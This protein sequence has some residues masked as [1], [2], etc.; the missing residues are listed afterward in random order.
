[1]LLSP[2]RYNSKT[3]PF[4]DLVPARPRAFV[5]GPI[6]YST[7]LDETGSY[8]AVEQTFFNRADD[9]SSSSSSSCCGWLSFRAGNK[10]I[11][12]SIGSVQRRAARGMVKSSA[13]ANQEFKVVVFFFAATKLYSVRTTVCTV[14]ESSAREIA[15]SRLIIHCC[16]HRRRRVALNRMAMKMQRLDTYLFASVAQARR[17]QKKQEEAVDKQTQQISAKRTF[18]GLSIVK[19]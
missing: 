2:D 13:E 14:L 9:N 11:L 4:F 10:T 17:I 19:E 6:E 18:S 12:A 7:L 15:Q 3:V 1:M 5:G 16:R 8:N